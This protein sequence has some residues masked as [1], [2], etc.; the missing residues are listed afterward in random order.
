MERLKGVIKVL[1]TDI[2]EDTKRQCIKN[3]AMSVIVCISAGIMLIMNIIR[4]SALMTVTSVILVV[5]FAFT[6]VLAGVFKN[7]RTSTAIMASVLTG[8]FTVFPI[9]GGNEGFAVLWLLLIPLFSISLFGIKI[10]IGMNAYFMILVIVL[11]YTPMSSI[12]DSMYTSNFMS[13]FPVLFMADS[14]TAQFLALGSEYYYRITKLQSYTDDMTKVYNRKYFMEML[15]SPEM[16]KDDLCITVI[17][18]NG[19][20]ETNDTLGHIAGDEMISSV[21]VS[22][23]KAF[24][25]KAVVARMG[26][27]E[28]A[29][30][31]FAGREE[32]EK[33]AAKMKEYAKEY[34]GRYID[35]VH[36]SAGVACRSEDRELTPEELYRQADRRM[37]EDKTAYYRQSGHDRRSR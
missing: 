6:G 2:H 29:V 3:L 4:H 11:Y 15:G 21:P 26:G 18:I 30:L 1:R 17:D 24:G 12:I 28:F 19:L 33:M 25:E 7:S 16:L 23:K 5:G 32:A 14:V 34:K 8:V 13:R 9:S 27:D 10:G 22:V 20:K 36:I 31:T 37:Y 35:K